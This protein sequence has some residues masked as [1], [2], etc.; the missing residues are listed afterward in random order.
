MPS[1]EELFALQN[2]FKPGELKNGMTVQGLAASGHGV[3]NACLGLSESMMPQ[4]VVAAQE[5]A[6]HLYEMQRT[7]G[8]IYFGYCSERL[9]QTVCPESTSKLSAEP[10]PYSSAFE[11]VIRHWVNCIDSEPGQA[12]VP[13]LE[14]GM[15]LWYKKKMDSL[16]PPKE[17]VPNVRERKTENGVYKE[18]ITQQE[19]SQAKY[20]A[21]SHHAEAS[22]ANG[23]REVIQL[24]IQEYRRKI[25]LLESLDQKIGP[26]C[27]EALWEVFR[28]VF[29]KGK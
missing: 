23:F 24:K 29:T 3:F 27:D 6:D 5:F 22:V 21:V 19:V 20:E 12:N 17:N 2:N 14:K 10:K 18:P 16:Q 13:E 26:E 25:T 15:L 7:E 9:Y 28:D 1:T 8:N 11:A 4:W